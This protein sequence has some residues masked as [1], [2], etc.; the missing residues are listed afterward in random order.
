MEGSFILAQRENLVYSY[1][2]GHEAG[3]QG[4]WSDH[5]HSEQPRHE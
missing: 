1:E 2:G 3:A 4:S 5:T